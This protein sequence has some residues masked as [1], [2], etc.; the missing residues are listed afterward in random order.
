[1]DELSGSESCWNTRPL[2]GST[3]LEKFKFK[4]LKQIQL[5]GVKGRSGIGWLEPRHTLLLGGRVEACRLTIPGQK[6]ADVSAQGSWLWPCVPLPRHTKV[7]L[8]L[9]LT[10]APWGQCPRTGPCGPLL[11]LA[12]SPAVA[13]A[14]AA[15][16]ARQACQAWAI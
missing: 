8:M 15:V 10:P 2:G 7:P 5:K 3:V 9:P 4:M 13:A 12:N 14:A 1:M 6:G 16:Q 11:L